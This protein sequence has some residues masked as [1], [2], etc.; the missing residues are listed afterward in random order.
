MLDGQW[1]PAQ[2]IIDVSGIREGMRRLRAL[3]QKPGVVSVECRRVVNPSGYL[4][5]EYEYLMV[6]GLDERLRAELAQ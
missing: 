6:V 2:E 3:R 5:N 1:H 4:A